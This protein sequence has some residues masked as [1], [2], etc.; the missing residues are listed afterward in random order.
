[1]VWR[2]LRA[3]GAPGHSLLSSSGREQQIQSDHNDGARDVHS[4]FSEGVIYTVNQYC[5]DDR[6]VNRPDPPIRSPS[7][8][9][10]GERG[11]E[12]RESDQEAENSVHRMYLLY[13]SALLHLARTAERPRGVAHHE[14]VDVYP[15][16]SVSRDQPTLPRFH[17]RSPGGM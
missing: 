1:M 7:S 4:L 11:P 2:V 15:T 8:F 6:I 13:Q 9:R 14:G 10:Q 16:G 5:A 3:R 12:S 17:I